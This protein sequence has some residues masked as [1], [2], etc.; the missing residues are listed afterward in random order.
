MYKVGLTGGIG[1]GKS[2][3]ARL[4]AAQ[5]VAVID[6]DVIAHRLVEPGQPALQAIASHF[7]LP[8]VGNGQ[9]D[10]KRLRQIVFSSEDAR[11]WLENLL[12]PLVYAE[13]QRQSELCTTA[14]CLMVIPLLL[15]TGRAGWVDRVLV[16]DCARAVQ[17]ERVELRDGLDPA[18]FDR[19]EAAQ[20][21]REARLAAADDILDNNH[22]LDALQ[23]H[24]KALHRRYLELASQARGQR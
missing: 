17:R 23:P 2:T 1:C 18:E 22:G 14:Y 8:L 3:V 20:I 16:V 5:G 13:M 10:R 21:S 15:E 9:L 19:I 6:A 24:V 4:F 12:H 11:Q 7:D